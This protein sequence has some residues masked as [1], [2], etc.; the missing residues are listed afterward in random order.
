[1]MNLRFWS[2][3]PDGDKRFSKIDPEDSYPK[4]PRSPIIKSQEA[5]MITR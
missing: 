5:G 4:Q 3:I 2:K 1:M